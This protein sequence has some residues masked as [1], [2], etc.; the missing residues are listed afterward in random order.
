M[1]TCN[2]TPVEAHLASLCVAI[3]SGAIPAAIFLSLGLQ[4]SLI[5]VIIIVT[6]I[7]YVFPW[8]VCKYIFTTA[9]HWYGFSSWAHRVYDMVGVL[10]GLLIVALY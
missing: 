4:L 9:H 1:K 7:S 2:L 10:S 5:K 8:C 6:A 3:V